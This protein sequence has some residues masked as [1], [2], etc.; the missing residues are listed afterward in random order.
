MLTYFPQSAQ[1]IEALRRESQELKK[2]REQIGTETFARSI[3]EKV[4]TR[5][6]QRLCGME[7]MWKTRKAPTALDFDKVNADATDVSPQMASLD[8]KVWSLEENFAVFADS[9]QRLSMRAQELHAEAMGDGNTP[10]LSFDKDDVDTLDFV[11]AAANLRSYVFG[12]ELRSKF[13]IKRLFSRPKDSISVLILTDPP[14]E[15]K[16]LA[17]SSLLSP[18]PMLSLLVFAFFRPLRSSVKI[19]RLHG[20]FSYLGHRIGSSPPKNC[21]HLT[22]R[23]MSA[24]LR[25]LRLRWIFVEQL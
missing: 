7:N 19:S 1:E 14:Y 16:W 5:D 13:D 12:I 2:I 17:T 4:F 24:V 18:L 22:L 3:F 23:V 25:G 9:L 21:P 6:I 11:A 20:W 8:Q 15:K 10:I